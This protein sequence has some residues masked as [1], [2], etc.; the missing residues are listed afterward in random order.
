MDIKELREIKKEAEEAI[1]E[2]IV[3]VLD[4]LEA[5]T[6]CSIKGIY[7]DIMEKTSYDDDRRK[8]GLSHVTIELDIF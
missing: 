2:K 5:K 1:R 4:D 8:Y 6:E 7:M 3:K